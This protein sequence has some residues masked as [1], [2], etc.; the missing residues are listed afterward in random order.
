MLFLVFIFILEL[1]AAVF[2]RS[3]FK[4]A[5]MH[6]SDCKGVG[7]SCQNNQECCTGYCDEKNIC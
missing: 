2:H 5:Q 1:V 4:M 3:P 6:P 7:D